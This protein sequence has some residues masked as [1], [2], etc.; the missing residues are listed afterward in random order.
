M[1]KHFKWIFYDSIN[2]HRIVYYVDIMDRIYLVNMENPHIQH[3]AMDDDGLITS[4]V[5]YLL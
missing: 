2:S 5:R 3:V 4:M 1:K